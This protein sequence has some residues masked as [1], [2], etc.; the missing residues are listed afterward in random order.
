M[1]RRGLIKAAGKAG[2]GALAVSAF[3][4]AMARQASAGPGLGI[5]SDPGISAWSHAKSTSHEAGW[6]DQFQGMC[7]DGT[8]WYAVSNEGDNQRLHKLTLDF[9]STI[10]SLSAPRGSN[11][12]G[13]PTYD[14]QRRQIYVPIEGPEPELIWKVTTGLSTAGIVPLAGR[15]P[16]SPAPQRWKCPWI[17]FNPADG[18]V[19]SSVF[20]D[21][22]RTDLDKYVDR[23]W[24]YDRDTG[25]LKKEIRLPSKVYAIQGGTF[26]NGGRN[27]YLAS[28]YEEATNERKHVYAYDFSAATDGRAVTSWGKVAIPD[29]GDEVECVVFAHLAWRNAPDTHISVGILDDGVWSGST[30]NVYF[31]H[32]AVPSPGLI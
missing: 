20:G 10:A 7:T 18:L 26:G 19:Y 23:V 16:G 3:G 29:A 32:F 11:H 21:P 1:N 5:A 30:D 4:G 8:Y 31:R 27:L 24:G 14:P 2:V 17:A 15:T 12:I 25:L 22:E 9:S 6:T 13:A 28:D